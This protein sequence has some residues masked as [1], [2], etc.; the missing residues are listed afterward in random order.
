MDRVRRYVAAL[1]WLAAVGCTPAELPDEPP[2]HAVVIVVDTLR[3]DALEQAATPT[4][5]G[6]VQRGARVARAWSDGTWTGPSLVSLFTGMHVREHGWD[7]D[8]GGDR[9]TRPLAFP[10]IPDTPTLAEVLRRAGFETTGIFASR[11]LTFPVGFDRGFKRWRRTVD[12]RVPD[13]V[14]EQVAGWREG[15][16]HLLYLH[17]MGP[18]EPLRPSTE[19]AHRWGL[20]AALAEH[21]RGFDTRWVRSPPA[22]GWPER[23]DTYRR[24]YFAVVEDSDARIGRILEALG[25]HL[26]RSLVVVTADH[27]EMLGENLQLGHAAGV[28]ESLT[29]IPLLAL[30]A[31]ALPARLNLAAVPDLITRRLGIEHSWSVQ[32]GAAQPLVSQREGALALSEDGR[33]K[34]VWDREGELTVS[35]LE[36]PGLD[37]AELRERAPELEQLRRRFEQR[38]AEGRLER[39]Q[40]PAEPE[41]LEALQA[42]G[43][44]ESEP[45]SDR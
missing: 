23:L 9:R 16:R 30:N 3:A 7:F 26:E 22:E 18:H 40:R 2:L 43:Y 5:D 21:P 29:H 10:P 31:G 20:A 33:W 27:G 17:L 4:L 35:D 41:V 6:L 32:L 39:P 15:Q 12:E 1:A 11:V 42:L 37:D 8:F 14:A 13:L 24:A 25:P 44:V 19:A 45:D 36:R 38:V 28:D 34:G